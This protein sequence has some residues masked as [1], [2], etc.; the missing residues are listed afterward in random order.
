MSNYPNPPVGYYGQ[1][2][3]QPPK[4]RPGGVT[5]VAIIAIIIGSIGILCC[6]GSALIGQFINVGN[7]PPAMQALKNDKVLTAINL[8]TGLAY[9]LIGVLAL[10]G[11]IAALG[12][13]RSAP[14]M[15]NAYSILSIVVFVGVAIA[16]LTYAMPKTKPLIE[17]AM[18]EQQ[19]AAGPG[20][21]KI[22]MSGIMGASQVLGLVIVGVFLVIFPIIVLAVMNSASTKAAF[23]AAAQGGYPPPGQQYYQQ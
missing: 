9:I 21:P 17:Q 3:M 7:Q 10:V 23:A 19:A 14:G 18:R 11:G 20:A 15:L 4:R 1:P 2:P 8:A 13:K 5:A 22:D 12:M 16:Q 6:G